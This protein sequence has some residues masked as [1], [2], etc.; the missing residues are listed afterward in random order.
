M[1]TLHGTGERGSA[2]APW[3]VAAATA[4][5]FFRAANVRAG[6]ATREEKDFSGG[7]TVSSE[8]YVQYEGN[9][10]KGAISNEAFTYSAER[11]GDKGF[12]VAR[13]WPGMRVFR[14]RG[15][16]VPGRINER[17]DAFGRIARGR[18]PC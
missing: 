3:Q 18:G 1:S 12:P 17:Q 14:A 9:V 7:R 13:P 15:S 2:R 16:G 4:R 8:L 6:L 11:M 10:A 5:L